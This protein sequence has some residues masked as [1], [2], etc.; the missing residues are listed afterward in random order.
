MEKDTVSIGYEQEKIDALR[1]YLA[2]KNTYLE[3]EIGKTMDALY[4][5]V[6]PANV[7]EFIEAKKEMHGK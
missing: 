2:H 1:I 4:A 7:R 3:Y 6:V 5:K